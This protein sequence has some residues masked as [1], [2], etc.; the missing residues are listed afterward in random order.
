MLCK[1]NVVLLEEIF[2]LYQVKGILTHQL[3]HHKH[4][5]DA[6]GK[7]IGRVKLFQTSLKY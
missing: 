1:M 5:L 6:T 4:H 7:L 3:N 2:V